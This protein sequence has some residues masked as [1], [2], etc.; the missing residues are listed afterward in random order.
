MLVF[1]EVFLFFRE[2]VSKTVMKRIGEGS[3]NHR[4]KMSES[5]F[6]ALDLFKVI[7]YF[8]PPFGRTSLEV[9]PSTFSKSKLNCSKWAQWSIPNDKLNRDDCPSTSRAHETI[10]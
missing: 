9:S 7:V 3:R 1:I 10:S 6:L 8:L 2:A 4:V 5:Q